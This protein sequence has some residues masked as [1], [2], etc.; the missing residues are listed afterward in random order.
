[1]C[2]NA[3][4]SEFWLWL[5][6]S[7]TD[8]PKAWLDEA[9]LNYVKYPYLA[10]IIARSVTDEPA[11]W[12]F[13]CF[14]SVI[15]TKWIV[16]AAHCKIQNHI[17]RT[18][19]YRD[20]V[21]NHTNTHLILRWKV[22]PGYISNSTVP[23]HDIALAKVNE[24][25]ETAVPVFFTN[26]A[27]QVQASVW[28]TIITMERRTYLTNDMEIYDVRIIN[29][30][31]CYERYGFTLD[32]TFICVN[33]TRDADCFITEFGP[34]FTA[35]ERV[36]GILRLM[37]NDCENKVAIFTNVTSYFEWISKET[38]IGKEKVI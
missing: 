7:A 26:G 30:I 19:L 11:G 35:T 38:G 3:I 21:H 1:M 23:W 36:L 34:I 9:D 33:M 5:L 2:R 37:P 18:L 4:A 17:H 6:W 12:I 15:A 28:K 14:G 27:Q 16:T 32:D 25:L 10:A 8:C 20:Y 22:H 31:F 13:T 24:D 29:P